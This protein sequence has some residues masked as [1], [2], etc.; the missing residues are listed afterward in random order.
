MGMQ[1]IGKKG[2]DLNVVAFAKKYEEIFNH[3]ANRPNGF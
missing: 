1:I 3:S 2:Y